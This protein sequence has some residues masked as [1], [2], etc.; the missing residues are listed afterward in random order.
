MSDA[1]PVWD[2]LVGQDAA[3]AVLADAA[4]GA[5]AIL[6]GDADDPSVVEE[7]RA[8]T[9]AWLL[10]GPPG[11]GRSVAARAFA[12]A[13]QCTGPVPGC[14]ECPGCRTTM[15]RSNG[16]VRFVATETSIISIDVARSL[17]LEAQTAPSQGRW[18]VLIVEDADRI[19]ERTANV[20][21]KAI[22]EPPERTVWLLCAPSPEDMIQ[23]IRSRCRHLGLRIPPAQA[24][25]DLLVSEGVADE[26]T[27]FEA[28]RAAQSHIGLARALARDP[29]QRRRRREIITAPVRVRSVGEAVFAAEALLKTAKEQADARTL[30]R[31][32]RE[33]REL[34]AR[35][36]LDESE[37]ANRQARTLIHQL[38]E[39]QKRRA[40]RALTDELDR[41][42]IDLLAIYRDVLMLQLGTGQE[43]I[44]ADLVDL[45]EEIAANSTPR[46]TMTRVGAI[47]DARRR[48]V[49]NG[50]ALLVLE[51]MTVSLRPQV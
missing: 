40:K 28:A 34:L 38:E 49:A 12:A 16:D 48:L 14:G 21:L 33:K 39:E 47:E 32:E 13:L 5:R 29:E 6:S 30:E 4:K 26:A 31:N 15:S 51:A 35:L 24:V 36:G 45:V 46:Q 18:R 44:N 11:S 2:E 25:A 37:S 42:L 22:E 27:A 1:R 7:Q 3:V 10:T 23:T 20:L 17:V 43:P 41:A 50:Q 9:H 8:M 19:Q